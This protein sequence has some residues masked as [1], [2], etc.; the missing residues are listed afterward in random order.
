MNVRTEHDLLGERTIPADAYWGIHTLRAQENF[1]AH[2]ALVPFRLIIAL[3]LVKKA[4]C[5]T[6]CQLEYLDNATAQ[7]MQAACDD[8]I[9]GT[10]KAEFPLDALQGGAGTSTNMNINEVIANRTL[11]LLG[12]TKGDYATVH[13]IEHVNMHQST[14]DVYPTALK[15]AVIQELRTLSA[16]LSALQNAFQNKEQEYS[17]ILTIGRTELQD[18]VPITLGA[19]FASFAE[20]VAR[21]RWRTFKCEERLRIVNIGGTAVGTGLGVPRRYIFLVIEKLRE[22]T[23]L[24]LTRA[25]NSMDQTA[26][27]DAF[28]ETAGMV[29]ACA[30]N[31]IK[32]AGD[33]R[34]LH[35]SGEVSLPPVQAGSS[36][37]PGK[38][39]PVICEAVIAAGLRIKALNTIVT[40][41][42]SLG[43]FQLCEFLPLLA[44]ALLESLECCTAAATMLTNH[45]PGIIAHSDVCTDH[46]CRSTTIITAFL[47]H[48]GYERA[49]NLVQAYNPSAEPFKAY[50]ERTLG[51]SLVATVLSPRN[52]MAMGYNDTKRT[53]G[54]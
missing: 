25:E 4:C 34:L 5:M 1:I 10:L 12:H 46:A 45:I 51:S 30:V 15:I 28:V 21:D 13:P 32:I 6:N 44:A 22:L 36:F 50:L 37:M 3:A 33:L 17:G 23:G 38:V 53:P 24:G 47:P 41:A 48:I 54:K 29:N 40:D 35:F 2:T 19:Q 8:V 39:N 7:A 27:A 18:A 11:E 16:Q 26:N 49:Q 52:I 20:A 9:A 43:T 42:A 31:L 14:N